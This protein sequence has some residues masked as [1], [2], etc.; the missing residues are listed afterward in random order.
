MAVS[1]RIGVVQAAAAAA[2]NAVEAALVVAAVPWVVAGCSRR[3]VQVQV[4]AAVSAQVQAAEVVVAC[5]P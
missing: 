5:T 4:E 1:I 3:A 2:E